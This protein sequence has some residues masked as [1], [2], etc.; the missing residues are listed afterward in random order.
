MKQFSHH[1][2]VITGIG[3]L[4]C[5]GIGREAFWDALEMGKS[6][7][8]PVDRF[9]T[10]PFPC[11]I[12]G[13]LWDFDP[14]DFVLKAD[15]RRWHRT[16]HQALAATQLALTDAEF[17]NANYNN[18]KIA[19]GMGTSVGSPDEEYDRYC[20]TINEEGWQ[21]LDKFSS[22]AS[23]GHASTATITAKYGFQGPA[24]TFASGCATGLDVMSWGVH[25]IRSGHADA[26]IVGATEAPINAPIFGVSSALGILSQHN[27]EP[28][29]AMRP[30][31]ESGDGLVLSESAVTLVLERADRAKAR[32][33]RILAE[34]AGSGSSAEGNNPLVLQRDG[35][36]ISRAIDDALED[37]A[38]MPSEL[39]CIHCHGVSLPMYDKSEVNAYK[40]IFGSH[41]YRMPITAPKSMVGQAY[42]VG[43]LINVT[44]AAMSLN[45][46]IIPP[47]INLEVPAPECDLDFVPSFARLNG[48]KN[49]MVTAMSFGGTHGASILRCPN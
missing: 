12:G 46:G 29:K 7:I 38:M 41:A 14:N 20:S 23:S 36:A 39:E 31:D 33:A 17:D 43:G 5:N 26:A 24:V 18:Q 35:L 37:A 6:G 13:Q 9:D 19:V 22:S 42:A 40:R 48:P 25:Q 49:A 1:P 34:I 4:S 47:T 32:G 21:A 3:I 28:E 15:I 30:F 27:D 2:I 10:S 45:T 16:V 8:G 11:H 44:S